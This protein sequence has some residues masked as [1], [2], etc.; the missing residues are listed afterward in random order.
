VR[1]DLRKK[2]EKEGIK[3]AREDLKREQKDILEIEGNK[4]RSK[5]FKEGWDNFNIKI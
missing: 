5:S 3:K 2:E 1:R 4:K